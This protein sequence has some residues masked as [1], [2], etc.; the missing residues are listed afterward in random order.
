MAATIV[1]VTV[2]R[3]WQ[4]QKPGSGQGGAREVGRE[5]DYSPPLLA[6][7]QAAWDKLCDT[8]DF[9]ASA[10]RLG[11]LMTIDGSNDDKIKPQGVDEYSFTDVDGGSEGAESEPER[12]A[13]RGEKMGG[14]AN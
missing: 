10:L 6:R 1:A 4:S 7:Q 14:V 2:V 9:E 12:G 5:G 13:S 11:L 8:Y 3:H